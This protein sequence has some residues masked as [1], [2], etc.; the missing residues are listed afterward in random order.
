V[1]PQ[2]LT[3]VAISLNRTPPGR[4]VVLAP[5]GGIVLVLGSTWQT[6]VSVNGGAGG[7]GLGQAPG[8]GDEGLAFGQ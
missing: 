2:T 7:P 6:G 1:S 5:P 3:V 4:Q 8:T